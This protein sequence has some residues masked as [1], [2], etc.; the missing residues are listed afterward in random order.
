[1]PL[2]KAQSVLKEVLPRKTFEWIY[3][4]ACIGYKWYQKVVDTLYYYCIRRN[5]DEVRKITVLRTILPY[6]MVGRKGLLAT[7]QAIYDIELR[8]IEGCLVECGVARGGCSALMALVSRE[9]SSNRVSWLFDS[10]DGLPPS[11]IEDGCPRISKSTNRSADRLSE[12]YCLGTFR[13]VEEL[14]F[15]KLNFNRDNIIL[16]KGWFQ[17]TLS[18]YRVMIGKIAI[19]RLDGDW[20]ESTKCCMENLYDNVASGGYVVIDDYA[21]VGCSK[22]IDDFLEQRGV[23]V[24]IT[25]DGR[26][27]GYFRK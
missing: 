24:E 2:V 20:Y 5:I 12:G 4:I 23:K 19:L 10:F 13:E 8:H 7:Y 3:D 6:T 17:D 18:R 26:G 9:F 16:V 21:L 22:A 11:T 27:G 14:F 1:M 15:Q 25:L